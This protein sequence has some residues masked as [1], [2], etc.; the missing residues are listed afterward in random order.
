MQKIMIYH[1]SGILKN[2]LPELYN[3]DKDDFNRDFSSVELIKMG[4]NCADLCKRF[5]L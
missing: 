5:S 3:I 2:I 4:V 1:E